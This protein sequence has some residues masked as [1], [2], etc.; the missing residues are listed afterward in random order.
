FR[1]FFGT[2]DAAFDVGVLLTE[3][4]MVLARSTA[5][6]LG[7]DIGDSLQVAFGT[8][9][10]YA[11]VAGVF[12]PLDD[13]AR[14]ALEDVALADIA[15]AQE[16]TRS[17]GRIDRIEVR[18]DGARHD[19][20]VAELRAALPAGHRLLDSQARAGATARLTRAF[21]TNLTALAL[22]ALVFGMFL[23]YNS[24]SFSVVQ[25]RPLLGLLRA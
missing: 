3:P 7:V 9:S 18:A 23:I 22:V 4:A 13:A 25:R 16:L 12:D 11:V 15:T 24:V 1:E 6:H 14:L 5:A 21:D 2:G 8:S 19:R 10:R 17:L 20:G